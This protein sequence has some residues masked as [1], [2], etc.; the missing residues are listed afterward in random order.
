MLGGAYLICVGI[1]LLFTDPR[2]LLDLVVAHIR[3][4]KDGL[5]EAFGSLLSW[6]LL[7]VLF[8]WVPLGIAIVFAL[9]V[10]FLYSMYAA[11][12]GLLIW[13]IFFKK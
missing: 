12:G 13:I 10:A 8:F 1:Y 7:L 4:L 9:P 11:L 3:S 2:V 6:A 5:F